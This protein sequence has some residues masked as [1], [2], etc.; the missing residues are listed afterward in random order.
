M[1]QLDPL[2]ETLAQQLK[3]AEGRAAHLA[4][5]VQESTV[6]A[7]DLGGGVASQLEFYMKE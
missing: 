3:K 1:S 2:L 7:Y 5:M 4:I 6:Q